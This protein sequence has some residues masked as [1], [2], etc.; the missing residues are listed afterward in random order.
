MTYQELMT[1][2]EEIIKTEGAHPEEQ[3]AHM[4][5]LLTR[6]LTD[7]G[8][9][10][11]IEKTNNEEERMPEDGEECVTRFLE[12]VCERGLD[13]LGLGKNKNQYYRIGTEACHIGLANCIVGKK[14]RPG[15]LIKGKGET[16]QSQLGW[17][18]KYSTHWKYQGSVSYDMIGQPVSEIYDIIDKIKQCNN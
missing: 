1:Q 5:A 2:V 15:I 18:R 14:D 12:M 4:N 11:D 16:L 3:C 6:Y 10:D 13:Y 8:V 17:T 9:S 7:R